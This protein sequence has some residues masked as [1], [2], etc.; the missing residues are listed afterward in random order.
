M[1]CIKRKISCPGYEK[2][3]FILYQDANAATEGQIHYHGR[4]QP[5]ILSPVMPASSTYRSQIFSKFLESSFPLEIVSSDEIDILPS[6]VVNIST[7]PVKSEML[8][9]ALAAIACIYLGRT[10]ADKHLTQIGIRHYDIAIRHMSQLLSHQVQTDDMIYTTVAFQMIQVRGL[11]SPKLP[12]RGFA[13]FKHEILTC[14]Y[15]YQSFHCPYGLRVWLAHMAGTNALLRHCYQNGSIEAPI[16]DIYRKLQ[17]MMMV[18]YSVIFSSFDFFLVP[19]FLTV[20]P[21][22]LHGGNGVA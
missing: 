7:R 6:L 10:L 15:L 18:I 9:R 19:I 21:D 11:H 13:V 17:K 8:E 1:R 5:L 16:N 2:G 12:E 22:I 14:R 3:R 4:E 20:L